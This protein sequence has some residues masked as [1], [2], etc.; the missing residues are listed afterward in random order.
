MMI[1]H[2]S[3]KFHYFGIMKA[4]SYINKKRDPQKRGSLARKKYY[5]FPQPQLPP[6]AFPH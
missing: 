6:W 5:F 2:S 1:G 3:I 4:T